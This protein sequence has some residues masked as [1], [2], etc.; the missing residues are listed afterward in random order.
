MIIMTT[1]LT[2]FLFHLKHVYYIRIFD[3][4]ISR[5]L[6]YTRGEFF[7]QNENKM[8]IDPTTVKLNQGLIAIAIITKKNHDRL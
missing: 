2:F 3:P 8:Q 4:Y 1:Q 7:E 5:T 6:P